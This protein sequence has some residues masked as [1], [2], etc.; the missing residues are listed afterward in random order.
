MGSVCSTT[1]ERRTY[2]VE[3]GSQRVSLPVVSLSDELSLALLITVDMGVRFMS[4][5]GEELAALLRPHDV[6]IVA[7]VATMGIPLAV[8]VIVLDDPTCVELLGTFIHDHAELW[9][10]DIGE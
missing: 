3:I 5:A 2:E 10:E 1:V 4:R 7:T 6:D 8:E 9:N